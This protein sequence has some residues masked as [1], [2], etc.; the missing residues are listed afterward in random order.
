MIL[1]IGQCHIIV[2]GQN[3]RRSAVRSIS[4]FIRGLFYNNCLYLLS[5]SQE[6]SK[7][8]KRFY[9]KKR[10][11]CLQLPNLGVKWSFSSCVHLRWPFNCKAMIV[12]RQTAKHRIKKPF[13]TLFKILWLALIYGQLIF[14]SHP[15]THTCSIREDGSAAASEP[16][17]RD[18]DQSCEIP[19]PILRNVL[20][21]HVSLFFLMKASIRSHPIISLSYQIWPIT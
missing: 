12:S 4:Y 3:L 1:Q 17:R 21:P 18:G 16:E 10:E 15:W 14:V 11:R 7:F 20:F 6:K 8:K 9:Q 19:Q 5:K 13:H 2:Q